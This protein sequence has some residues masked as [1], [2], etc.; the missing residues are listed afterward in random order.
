MPGGG[1]RQNVNDLISLTQSRDTDII[2]LQR[3]TGL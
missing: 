3:A 1:T 2:P